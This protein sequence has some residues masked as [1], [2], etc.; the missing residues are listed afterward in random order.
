[1]LTGTEKLCEQPNNINLVTNADAVLLNPFGLCKDSLG[2]VLDIT[3]IAGSKNGDSDI[4]SIR[5]GRVVIPPE[6]TGQPSHLAVF[7]IHTH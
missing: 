6:A 1:M 5:V 2:N 3:S 4:Y 7:E